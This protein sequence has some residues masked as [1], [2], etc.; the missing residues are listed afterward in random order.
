MKKLIT[1][2]FTVRVLSFAVVL[3]L[4]IINL[5]MAL[6]TVAD[7][8]KTYFASLEGGRQEFNCVSRGYSV[9]SVARTR[10]LSDEGSCLLVPTPFDVK[11]VVYV[12]T[13]IVNLD[14][15]K[16]N[17]QASIAYPE[18]VTLVDKSLKVNGVASASSE[19]PI[20]SD[21]FDRDIIAT[22]SKRDERVILEYAFVVDPAV[23]PE[24]GVIWVRN[25]IAINFEP[26][27]TAIGIRM[28]NTTGLLVTSTL[29][30]VFVLV[31]VGRR[32]QMF[33]KNR[34]KRS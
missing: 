26:V 15:H 18:G 33:F 8:A 31:Y 21:D 20:G 4:G 3:I 7:D 1:I 14:G 32:L 16:Q 29:A 28:L 23:F 22:S 6:K 27:F 5:N 30:L 2:G 19:S 11:R 34:K 9:H 10:R 25:D 17:V 13:E 24:N 12:T